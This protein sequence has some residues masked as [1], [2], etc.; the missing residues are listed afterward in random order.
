MESAGI[1]Y[2]SYP[3]LGGFADISETSIIFIAEYQKDKTVCIMCMEH[4]PSQ[5]H[6]GYEISP[7]LQKR[8]IIVHHL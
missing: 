2:L 8:G 6:R 7:R 3:D 1:S 5:C 4:D